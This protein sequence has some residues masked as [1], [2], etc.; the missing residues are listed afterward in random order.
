MKKQNSD[1]ELKEQGFEN[2]YSKLQPAK[3]QQ[4]VG[5]ENLKLL[6]LSN[7]KSKTDRTN[8]KNNVAKS[9]SKS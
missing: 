9:R 5:T 1:K 2:I 8:G 6:R 4:K 3:K 7:R